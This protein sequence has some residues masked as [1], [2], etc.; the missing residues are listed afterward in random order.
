MKLIIITTDELFEG[1]AEP[2]NLLFE[3]GLETL[4]IRKPKA[5]SNATKSLIDT[6]DA[7][8]HPRI[9][10]HDHYELTDC[11]HLQG[12]H[13]NNRNPEAPTRII[14]NKN[15]TISR[16]CH[17][18]TELEDS[19]RSFHYVFLSPVFDS[20]S[21]F[22]Y[23]QRFSRDDLFQ[24]NSQGIINKRVIALGGIHAENISEIRRYGFGGVAMIGAV[25]ADYINDRNAKM[26]IER[27][28]LL[29]KKC[30]EE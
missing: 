1:E 2:L 24:A 11:Y 21:K 26:L 12:I 25:W 30:L 20:I 5:S 27:F 23:K 7:A 13:L 18:I 19:I 15:P 17:T 29:N 3:R 28:N 10:L 9:V 8:Y 6:I 16:S 22:G 14:N 4:H